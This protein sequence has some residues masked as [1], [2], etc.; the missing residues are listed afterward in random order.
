MQQKFAVKYECTVYECYGLS[1]KDGAGWKI[2]LS[3]KIDEITTNRVKE[4]L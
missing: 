3:L 4:V 2:L 1:V